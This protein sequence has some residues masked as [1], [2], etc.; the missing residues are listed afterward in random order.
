ML[1]RYSRGVEANNLIPNNR[2]V[3]VKSNGLSVLNVHSFYGRISVARVH[4]LEYNT[5]YHAYRVPMGSRAN[6][7]V[8]VTRTHGQNTCFTRTHGQNMR[9]WP[10]WFPTLYVSIWMTDWW[11]Y[12][13]IEVSKTYSRTHMDT[14]NGNTGIY[15]KNCTW[16]STCQ[17]GYLNQDRPR[18]LNSRL[19]HRQYRF[20]FV[21]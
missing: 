12:D 13:N 2:I 1:M 19:Q 14:W 5:G 4:Y 6:I 3:S 21:A 7:H 20:Q 18:Q 16:I 8:R 9:I 17:A 10:W 11:I 15:Y